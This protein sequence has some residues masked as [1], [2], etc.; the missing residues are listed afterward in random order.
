[1]SNIYFS[2][3]KL[4]NTY[5]MQKLLWS[6]DQNRQLLNVLNH[7][8]IWDKISK[9]IKYWTGSVYLTNIST[10]QVSQSLM[11][12]FLL[13]FLFLAI[14]SLNEHQLFVV[15]KCLPYENFMGIA[16]IL[17]RDPVSDQQLSDLAVNLGENLTIFQFQRF[18][19]FFLTFQVISVRLVFQSSIL[20]FFI[21]IVCVLI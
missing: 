10:M 16:Y 11:V 3:S 18:N 7:N 19:L 15:K 12:L 4:Q 2:F 17:N 6:I 5:L 21:L 13:H 8:M 9:K 20:Y 14:S 1:M